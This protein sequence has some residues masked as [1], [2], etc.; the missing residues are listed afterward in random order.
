M[1][2]Y[3]EFGGCTAGEEVYV[4]FHVEVAPQY[5][6]D[7]E[8]ALIRHIAEC[9]VIPRSQYPAEISARLLDV[10]QGNSCPG[11]FTCERASK[12]SSIYV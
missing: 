8:V 10:S 1:N 2:A 5:K 4:H 9:V 3:R 11:I 7:I 12:E 6:C